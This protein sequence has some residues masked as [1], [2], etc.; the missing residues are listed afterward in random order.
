M[1]VDLLMKQFNRA[2]GYKNPDVNSEQYLQEFMN[3]FDE[4]KNKRV[5]I[6]S[7]LIFLVL[8]Y[9]NQIF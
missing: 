7:I 4:L 5:N 3:W 1:Y 2:K 9:L 6:L 8:I